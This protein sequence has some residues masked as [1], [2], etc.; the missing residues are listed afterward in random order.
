[1]IINELLDIPILY[2]S[3]YINENKSE[4][5]KLLNTVNKTDEWEEWILYILKAIEE[6]SNKTIIKINSIKEL[7]DDT[8]KNCSRKCF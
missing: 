8:I 3:S 6:T 7:L 2:L 4:Y 5:Y 1:M